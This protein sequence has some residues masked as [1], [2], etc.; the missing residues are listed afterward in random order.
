MPLFLAGCDPVVSIA[1]AN[2]PDW[3]ICVIIGAVLT[4]IVRP[5]L[6]F[7]G[8]ERYLRPLIVFYSS[9]I[10]LVALVTWIAFFNRT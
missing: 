5:L 1:G 10:V 8:C 9:M 6:L 7:A 2:F 3:L 4:A